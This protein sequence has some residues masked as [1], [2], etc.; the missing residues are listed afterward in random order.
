[1]NS[2]LNRTGWSVILESGKPAL[3][4]MRRSFLPTPLQP[5][6]PVRTARSSRI[7]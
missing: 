3:T 4:N 2:W 5:G 7:G 1:L 6:T